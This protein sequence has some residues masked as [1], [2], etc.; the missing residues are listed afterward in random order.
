VVQ[1]LSDTPANPKERIASH[2]DSDSP[3]AHSHR[4][5]HRHHARPT[6]AECQEVWI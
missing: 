4:P 3:I 2:L 5:N 1:F 6:Q